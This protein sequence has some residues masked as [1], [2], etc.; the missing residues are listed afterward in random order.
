MMLAAI[1]ALAARPG[2]DR[3]ASLLRT[4]RI[5]LFLAG[6][7]ALYRV[8][9]AIQLDLLDGPAKARVGLFYGTIALAAFAFRWGIGR[10]FGFARWASVVAGLLMAAILIRGRGAFA[11]F[12]H[13]LPMSPSD[14]LVFLA[15]PVMIGG[16]IVAAACCGLA[17]GDTAG[18][19]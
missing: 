15:W 9:V 1:D 11:T 7:A 14:A 10:R 3:A 18:W 16:F 8:A 4:A 2:H 5:A 6:A 12:W 17:R 19:R 13:F